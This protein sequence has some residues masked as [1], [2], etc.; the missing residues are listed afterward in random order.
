MLLLLFNTY[1]NAML[2]LDKMLHK[3]IEPL[4]FGQSLC[5][6]CFYFVKEIE[7]IF[8]LSTN[9]SNIHSFIVNPALCLC[10]SNNHV[11]TFHTALVCVCV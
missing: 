4:S 2:D 6:F 7:Y 1:I 3:H 11:H 9:T 5:L 10:H 8:I